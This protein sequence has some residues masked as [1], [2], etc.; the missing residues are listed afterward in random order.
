MAK[1]KVIDYTDPAN[2]HDY[3]EKAIKEYPEDEQYFR[4]FWAWHKTNINNNNGSVTQYLTV[5]YIYDG[6]PIR[7]NSLLHEL[8]WRVNRW[9]HVLID[10]DI[11]QIESTLRRHLEAY[12]G[13]TKPLN[14][15]EL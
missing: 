2:R 9:G 5:F 13:L 12:Y 15:W 10:Q 3:L 6:K 8:G 7:L 14:F 1:K 4:F 11:W